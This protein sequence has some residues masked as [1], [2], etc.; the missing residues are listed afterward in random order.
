MLVL[1]GG[2]ILG[3]TAAVRSSSTLP[4]LSTF[5]INIVAVIVCFLIDVSINCSYPIPKSLPFVPPGLLSD[6]TWVEE[7]RS[8]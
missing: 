5:V 1:T 2:S 6:H 8:E 3:G 4:L 7:R